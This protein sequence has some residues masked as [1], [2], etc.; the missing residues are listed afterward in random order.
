MTT[1]I[2]K[3]RGRILA[4]VAVVA[5]FGFTASNLHSQSETTSK[6][7]A[8]AR[9]AITQAGATSVRIGCERDSKTIAQLRKAINRGRSNYEKYYREGVITKDQLESLQ[10]QTA[11]SLDDLAVPNCEEDVKI[12]LDR[13]TEHV[14][15]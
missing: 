3:N 12:F 1:P 8:T 11:E 2:T 13:A 9:V 15:P 14:Q 6:N 5:A 10:K 4:Y 7:A